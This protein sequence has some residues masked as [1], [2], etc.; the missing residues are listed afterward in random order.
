M[1][2]SLSSIEFD[3]MVP[4]VSVCYVDRSYLSNKESWMNWTI[5]TP[6]FG[7]NFFFLIFNEIEVTFWSVYILQ[8]WR[9][10]YQLGCQL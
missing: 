3:D 8:I 7:Q 4:F 2:F 9:V 6:F 1:V 5:A 10:W